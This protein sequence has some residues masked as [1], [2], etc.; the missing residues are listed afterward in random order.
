LF[1]LRPD[2]N[3][4]LHFDRDVERK[5]SHSNGTSRMSADLWPKEFEDEIRET[6][7]DARL[8]VEPGA[9]FTIPKT[10]PHAAMRSRSPSSRF[11]LARM[12][13]AVRRAAA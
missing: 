6:V 10:R 5:L 11:R 13:T 3:F 8:P 12:E 7:E 9:E 1:T 4:S 2:F